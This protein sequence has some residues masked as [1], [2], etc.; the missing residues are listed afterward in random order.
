MLTLLAKLFIKDRENTTSPAT[1]QAYGMLCGLL[2]IFLNLLLFAGKI[3]AGTLTA[4]VAITADAFN[5]L[6]DAGSSLITLIGFKMAG[7]KPDLDHPFGHG[8]IEY[9]SGL[10]VSAL[11]L[12]MGFELAKTSVEKIIHPEAAELTTLSALILLLA[13][14][15]KGY[16]AL[17]NRRT[18]AKI[19]SAA[20]R[21]T[22][23]D[24][25]SD[26]VSTSVVLIC[27]VISHFTG[28][29]LD[30][31]CGLLVSG[32][33]L[34][35]GYSAAKDTV[36]PLLGQAPDPAFIRQIQSIVMEAPIITGIHD[37]IIHD[38]G[39]GRQMI[40]LHAEIPMHV[41]ILKAHDM[42]DNIEVNLKQQ[43]GCDAVIHMDPIATDDALTNELRMK[44][45]AFAHEISSEISIHDFRM[46]IGE[47]HT[48]LIFDAVLPYQFSADEV[49]Q[50]LTQKISE[51]PGDYRAVINIDRPFV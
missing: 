2:G 17:Y 36:N 38:Y 14:L 44:I 43:L 8:R 29:A 41:D 39:P 31:W 9:I 51:L 21:A 11:I 48:N 35:S 23:T 13:I 25:L 16:M 4:S 49:K 22:A 50:Q 5:N 18:A 37:L 28:L 42:I 3:L 33:I 26:M 19:D 20:M 46:V 1:R 24:S 15:V 7:Q 47:T 30:G 40:S 32:F 45:S 12:L 34:F 10:I 27:S 6:S